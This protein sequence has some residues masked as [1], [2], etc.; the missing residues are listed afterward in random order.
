LGAAEL[1]LLPAHAVVVNTARG[2]LIDELALAQA[3]KE[4]R[5]GAAGLDVLEVEPPSYDHPLFGLDNAI[6]TPH[7][8]GLTEECAERMGM[9]SVQ[10]VLDYFAET[11]NP[12]L[13]VNGP[14]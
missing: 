2:G 6:I 9:V 5:L 7:A 11:L 13:V 1:A 12:D 8:A 3:L 10:N 14:F 4:G